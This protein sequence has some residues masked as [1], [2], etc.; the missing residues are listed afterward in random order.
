MFTRSGSSCIVLPSWASVNV[1]TFCNSS[2]YV[3]PLSSMWKDESQNHTV[4]VGRGSNMQK[5][6]ENQ[7]MSRSWRIFLKNCSRPKKDPWTTLKSE[8][9]LWII[10]ET[11]EIFK[12][13]GYVNFWKWSFFINSVIILSY[14]ILSFFL[15]L[16]SFS[17][18]LIIFSFSFFF[19][20]VFLFF[21]SL[22]FCLSILD[23]YLPFICLF[24]MFIYSLSILNISAICL[25][26]TVYKYYQTY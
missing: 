9:Q 18:S 22:S 21:L 11:T 19:L 24:N 16:L 4:T 6:L 2:V 8:K 26:Y 15:S 20:F 7:R 1:S 14:T 17:L 25:I 13:Q 10:Q 23:T 12:I 5:I 3:P